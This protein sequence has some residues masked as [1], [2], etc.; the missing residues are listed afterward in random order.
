MS[1]STTSGR[2]RVRVLL[3]ATRVLVYDGPKLIAT[4]ERSTV[5]GSMTLVLDQTH[6][7]DFLVELA[8]CQLRF[9]ITQ[10]QVRHVR[11]V[12]SQNQTPPT[13]TGM[14]PGGIA[15]MGPG[16]PGGERDPGGF[17]GMP[18]SGTN[19]PGGTAYDPNLIEV[20]VYGMATLYEKFH[21]AKEDPNN[22]MNP[23]N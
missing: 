6:V 12:F 2:C 23:A 9:Q 5:R 1:H 22:P 20:T 15:P 13:G 3:R 7:H 16:G 17:P 21:V 14:G 10:L 4:H 11:D 19:Q 8:N 18:G